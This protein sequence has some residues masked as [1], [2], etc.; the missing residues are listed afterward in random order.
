MNPMTH[1]QQMEIPQLTEREID[2]SISY[3]QK[4][5]LLR[6]LIDNYVLPAGGLALGGTMEAMKALTNLKREPRIYSIK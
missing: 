3:D 6:P 2:D 4:P 5:G 1:F